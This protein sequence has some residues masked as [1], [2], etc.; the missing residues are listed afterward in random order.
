MTGEIATVLGILLIAVAL[1]VSERLR[2]DLVA[3]L[4]L[5]AVILTGLVEPDQAFASLGS[6]PVITV[7]AIFI[8]SHGLHCSGVAHAIGRRIS[9]LAGKNPTRLTVLIMVT[10][11]LLSAF[12]NNIGATAVLLP[13]IVGLSR[14]AKIS[15]SKLLIP[16]SFASLSGG[17]LT[18]I[19]T[20]SNLLVNAA[21]YEAGLEVLDLFEFAPIGAVLLGLNILYMVLFGRKLLPDRA[22]TPPFTAAGSNELTETYSLGERLF[23]IRIPAGSQLIGR[24]LIDSH[25]RD[26]WSL[27]VLAVEHGTEEILDPSPDTVLHRGDVLLLEGDLEAFRQRDVKPYLEIL[28]D[29]TWED[30]H[31]VSAD[32][33][34]HEVVVAPRS[35]FAGRTLIETDFREKYGVSV[36]GIWRGDR[37]ILT[38]LGERPLQIGDAL[39]LQGARQKIHILERE[40]DF[41]FLDQAAAEQARLQPKM[42][43][44]AIAALA[45][46]IISVITGWLDLPTATVLAAALMILSGVLKMEEAQRAIELR[47]VFIIA[48]MIPLGLAM[49]QSGAAE[50]LANLVVQLFGRLGP[51]GVLAGITVF[52]GL[53]VQVMSNSTTAVL[54]TPIA[55]N[56]ASSL[57]VNPTPFAVAVA[58]G[59]SAAFL[60][61]IAHQSNL[62]VMGAGGY[63]FLDYTKAG[64][65]IWLLYLIAATLLIP[66]LFPLV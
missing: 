27:N 13:A 64:I 4:V 42:A 6:P 8:V 11:G 29:R 18:L 43:P 1:F 47:A 41:L 32:I 54:I 7:G 16:L 48:A 65:G 30:H 61:P 38:D 59:A 24:A 50:Y 33:G 9:A 3:L 39:L 35:A 55:L 46:M 37:P 22:G 44:L 51:T 17:M 36:V 60:T 20:P 28:P 52:A 5:L 15:P 58:L 21:L 12:M 19:G 26:T 25:L 31:L 34:L 57:N 62:L 40:P 49:E 23:R 14:Q 66:I 10:V 2:P 45:L 56:A 53:A 63:R